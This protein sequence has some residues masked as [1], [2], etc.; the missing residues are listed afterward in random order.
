MDHEKR[1]RKICL[2]LPEAIEKEAWGAPTYR[3]GKGKIFA[4][5]VD[6]HHGDGRIALWCAALPGAQALLMDS[7]S[8]RFFVPPYVGKGG[9]IGIHLD[10]SNDA[11]VKDTVRRAYCAVAPEKLRDLVEQAAIPAR[12]KSRPP[13]RKPAVRKRA[14]R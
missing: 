13:A 7:D 14:A 10:K 4:M 8:V 3:V 12:K 9:W 6:N 1:A 5:Y 2:A 11:L